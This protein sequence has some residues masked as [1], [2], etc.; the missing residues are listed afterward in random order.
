[1]RL[2]F[3]S[4]SRYILTMHRIMINCASAY[5]LGVCAVDVEPDSKKLAEPVRAL[6]SMVA[7]LEYIPEAQMDAACAVCGAGLAFSYYFINAMSDG[8]LKIGLS[9]ASAVKF[10][11]KTVNCATQVRDK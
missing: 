8:A 10:A 3:L 7:K 4:F 5:G 2:M 11:A 9:R 1:M 6:L